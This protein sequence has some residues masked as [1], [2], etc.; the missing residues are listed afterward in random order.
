MRKNV[1]I[2]HQ[3]FLKYLQS[4]TNNHDDFALEKAE[5]I[6]IYWIVKIEKDTI[7]KIHPIFPKTPP[8]FLFEIIDIIEIVNK[9]FPQIDL[10]VDFVASNFAV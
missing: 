2:D 4:Q 1:E 8:V 10:S 3:K 5:G 9:Y 7:L 6:T